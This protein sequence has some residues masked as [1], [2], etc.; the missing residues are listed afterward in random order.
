MDHFFV[1][2][3]SGELFGPRIFVPFNGHKKTHKDLSK[4][5]RCGADKFWTDPGGTMWTGYE[6]STSSHSDLLTAMCICRIDNLSP[7]AVN[8]YS[9]RIKFV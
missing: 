7:V 9:V 3:G 6:F 1:V 2:R 5:S 4:L 8:P